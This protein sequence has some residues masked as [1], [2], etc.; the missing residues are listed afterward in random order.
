MEEISTDPPFMLYIVRHP[1][2]DAGETIEEKLLHYFGSERYDYVSG[3]ERLRVAFRRA[4]KPGSNEPLPIDWGSSGTTAV[5]VLLDNKLAQDQAWLQYVRNI[6]EET[7]QIGLGARV[8]PVAMEEGVLRIGVEEEAL[9]WHDWGESEEGRERQLLR[10]LTDAFIRMLRHHL[11]E[12]Q[13]PGADRDTLDDYLEN[14]QVFLSHCK[15]DD[16]GEPV[17][18]ALRTWLI[19]NA[20]LA[21]FIDVHDI[22]A[23]VSFAS[24][25]D[26]AAGRG[27]MV[28]IYSDQYSSREWCRRE[29][30]TAKRRNLP[31]LL[32]DC[33][34]DV[35]TRSFPYLG[36][37]PCIRMNPEA[38]DRLDC[39][40]EYLL[41]EIFQDFLWRCRVE[42]FRNGFP[43]T[44]FLAR[45]PELL[46]LAT[47]P[48]AA[49]GTAWDIVFP[50]PPL[51]E[52]EKQLF[53]DV[54]SDVR[55]YSLTEWL[56]E[57]KQ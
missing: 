18:L 26:R 9:R 41:D 12:L 16:H 31:M 24:V 8:I 57:V 56:A 49:E 4:N 43:Q 21:P 40:T 2:F 36:N 20:S 30:I 3:G 37:V 51:G 10:A 55:V 35:D 44:T 45:A 47:R 48:K 6:A 7:D 17:A 38:M 39:I 27:V 32:V 50:G 14:V 34:H 11:S 52:P 29:V 15:H 46:S 1:E 42:G 33:L 28:A 19:N 54:V 25:L 23:G 53:T 5:V 22:P 13:H